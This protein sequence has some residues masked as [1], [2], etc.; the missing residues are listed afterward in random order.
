MIKWEKYLRID[1]MSIWHTCINFDSYR[2]HLKN[3]ATTS[4]HFMLL[5]MWQKYDKN[6]FKPFRITILILRSI[7]NYLQVGSFAPWNHK[8]RRVLNQSR[9]LVLRSTINSYYFIFIIDWPSP[10][11]LNQIQT[12]QSHYLPRHVLHPT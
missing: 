11:L 8:S 12:L 1:D 6:K 9:I 5:I 7:W 2:W 3:H 4:F 10:R